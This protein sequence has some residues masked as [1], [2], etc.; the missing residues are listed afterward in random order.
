[1]A[2]RPTFRIADNP[3]ARRIVRSAITNVIA[4]VHK[5]QTIDKHKYRYE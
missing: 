3:Q 1:L 4:A 2:F 5:S